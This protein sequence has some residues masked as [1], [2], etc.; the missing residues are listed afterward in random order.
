MQTEKTHSTGTVKPRQINPIIVM[1]TILAL[2]VCLTY[3]VDSGQYARDGKLVVPGSYQ[4]LEVLA[5][6]AL[7]LDR[8]GRHDEALSVL[9]ETVPDMI[10]QWRESSGRSTNLIGRMERLRLIVEA[11]LQDIARN[12]IKAS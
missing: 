8:M 2:A 5:Y 6:T 3:C 10:D 1:L 11:Y 4:T 9:Q 7:A 12:A